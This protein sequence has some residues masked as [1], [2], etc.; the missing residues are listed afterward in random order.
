MIKG[1]RRSYRVMEG[2]GSSRKVKE[3]QGR[4]RKVEEGHEWS[5]PI[6][7]LTFQARKVMCGWLGADM[8]FWDI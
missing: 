6:T 3:G 7:G 1:N 8:A 5:F 2:Q 4:S